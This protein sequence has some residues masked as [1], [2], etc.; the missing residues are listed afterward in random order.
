MQSLS[1][2]K[3]A[4]ELRFSVYDKDWT[5]DDDLLGVSSLPSS[6][7]ITHGF[8]GHETH[9]ALCCIADLCTIRDSQEMQSQDSV[10]RGFQTVVQNSR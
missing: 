10:S 7:F 6:E 4:S 8:E 5:V 2:C 1:S 3:V 9:H